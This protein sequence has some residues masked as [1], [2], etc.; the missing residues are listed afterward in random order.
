MEKIIIFGTGDISQLAYFYLT[1]NSDYKVVAFTVD[2][3]YITQ[4][5]F[6]S[7]PVLLLKI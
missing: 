4:K 3:E 6:E 2:K 5:K 7:L 1:Q